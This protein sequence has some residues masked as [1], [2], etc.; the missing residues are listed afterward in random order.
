MAAL[1]IGP[2]GTAARRNALSAL[3]VETGRTD[4]P[5][6][7][8]LSGARFFQFLSCMHARLRA[9]TLRIWMLPSGDYPARSTAAIAI[10]GGWVAVATRIY[11]RRTHRATVP[12]QPRPQT[13]RR[14]VW[15]M[16]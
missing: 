3:F 13:L 12:A 5:G 6:R 10:Y 7:L 8:R 14:P 16:E 9:G 1:V 4:R 15:P 2:P 11:A